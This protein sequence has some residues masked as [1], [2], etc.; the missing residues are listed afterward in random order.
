[1]LATSI[2]LIVFR[3]VHIVGAIAWG[4][5]IF[6]FVLFLQPTAKAVGPAAGPF[7]RELLGK[8]RVVTVVLWI[9]GTTIVGGA[10]LY[11]HDWQQTGSLGDFVGTR[12]GLWLTIGSVSAVVAFLVGLLGT[13]PTID[14]VLSLGGQIAA[15]GDPPPADLAQELQRTQ[16]RARTLAKTNLTFVALA[17]V[18]MATARYW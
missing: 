9:A 17:A 4:G 10:F 3:I 18:A 8:R 13:K 2:Y 7:M 12:F 6:L 16:A 15:A 5:A 1:V 11:W 14:R